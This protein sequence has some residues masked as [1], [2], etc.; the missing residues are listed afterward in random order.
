MDRGIGKL[1]LG[2]VQFGLDYGVTNRRGK[3]A[4]AVAER[5]VAQALAAGIRVF[6]TAAVYGGPLTAA[7]FTDEAAQP[8]GFFSES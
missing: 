6:D 1:G 7:V 3:V 8:T 2:T 5:I 4:S